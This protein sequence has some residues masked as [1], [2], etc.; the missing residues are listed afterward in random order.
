MHPPYV[1]WILHVF[2]YTNCGHNHIISQ[3]FTPQSNKSKFLHFL[4]FQKCQNQVL[5]FTH[6]QYSSCI[7]YTNTNQPLSLGPFPY[8]VY[9]YWYTYSLPISRGGEEFIFCDILF[10]FKSPT[11]DIFI[12]E[13]YDRKFSNTAFSWPVINIFHYDFGNYDEYNIPSKILHKSFVCFR[14]GLRRKTPSNN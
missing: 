10:V 14:N 6:N 13:N 5:T 9:I 8:V 11:V 12:K 1:Y 3:L 2:I 7:I 4:P